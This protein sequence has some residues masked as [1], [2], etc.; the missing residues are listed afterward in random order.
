MLY[1]IAPVPPVAVTT[2]VA[3][4]LPEIQYFDVAAM[5]AETG[6]GP[7]TAIGTFIGSIQPFASLTETR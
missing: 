7:T 1:S 4:P 5:V 6:V 3:P 2:N